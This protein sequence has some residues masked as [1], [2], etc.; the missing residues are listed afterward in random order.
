MRQPPAQRRP[1]PPRLGRSAAS[2]PVRHAQNRHSLR[3]VPPRSFRRCTCCRGLT[4]GGESPRTACQVSSHKLPALP[5]TNQQHSLSIRQGRMVVTVV[6]VPGDAGTSDRSRAPR[7][8]PMAIGRARAGEASLP[9]F[10]GIQPARRLGGPQ[11]HAVPANAPHTTA[12]RSDP[13]SPTRGP[14]HATRCSAPRTAPASPSR[15]PARH[16]TARG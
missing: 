8:R 11:P 16:P 5:T 13:R 2:N 14:A 7:L 9:Q 3:S 12:T 4:T 6:H 1:R 10:T 15:P